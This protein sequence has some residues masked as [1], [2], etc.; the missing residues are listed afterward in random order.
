MRSTTMAATAAVLALLAGCAADQ[1]SRPS[2][3][4]SGNSSTT[5]QPRTP[6][7]RT[8]PPESSAPT[9]TTPP[10][11]PLP[12]ALPSI[13][14]PEF[15][16]PP[17]TKGLVLGADV[18]W[19]QCPEGTGIPER[20][21]KGLPMPLPTARF[22]V[23]GLTNGPAFTPNPCLEDQPRW[24]RERRLMAAAYAVT[25]YPDDATLQRLRD[26]GPYDGGSRLGGLRNVGYQQALFNVATMQRAGLVS[27][28]IWVDVEPVLLFEWSGDRRAN[29]AV[30]VGAAQGYADAGYAVGTYSTPVLWNAV[31]GDLAL[32]LPEWRAAGLTSRAEALRRCR[33]DWTFQGGDAV[34]A[35]C[36]AGS[37]DHDTTCPGVGRELRHWFHQ[38]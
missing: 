27:P 31:V 8:A 3:R 10:P 13:D 6:P 12:S 9:R 22:V 14:V 37:R 16:L 29:A 36:V 2:A 21:G 20:R 11:S 35:Q 19:P 5:T 30:V 38:F 25:S 26:D 18:S 4:P 17:R 15:R 28:V 23:L 24:V 1:P 32:G 7:S 33:P 34:L